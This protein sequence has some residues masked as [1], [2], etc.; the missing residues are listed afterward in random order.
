MKNAFQFPSAM[1][2]FKSRLPTSLSFAGLLLGCANATVGIDPG[3]GGSSGSGGGGAGISG[4]N[5]DLDAKAP[6]PPAPVAQVAAP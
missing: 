6:A 3:S 2:L 1:T 5:F 4:P